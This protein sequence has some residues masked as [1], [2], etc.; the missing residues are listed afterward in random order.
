[1]TRV[2][3]FQGFMRSRLNESEDG[4]TT[5]PWGKDPEGLGPE[6]GYGLYGANPEDEEAPKEGEEGEED[7]DGEEEEE[8]N[9]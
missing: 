8:V 5:D 4:Y 6:T 2:K 7:E 3:N 1:M 9:L